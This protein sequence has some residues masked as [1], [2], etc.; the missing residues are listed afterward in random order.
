M[1][2]SWFFLRQ[3][4]TLAGVRERRFL[5]QGNG[6]L[7]GGHRSIHGLAEY[8]SMPFILLG[9]GEPR[10]VQSGVV[11]A[12]LLR[13][14]GITPLLG[15]TFRSGEDR[16]GAAPVLVLSYGFWQN[17]LGGDPAIVGRTFEMND[18]IHTVIGVLPPIPQYPD[19]NDIYMPT[20]ACPFRLRP[21]RLKT[22]RANAHASS[23]EPAPA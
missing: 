17:E 12:E 7:Q 8:H 1:A 15:R 4:A 23:G 9:R 11:S 20:S 3:P 14:V 13:P 19:E 22:G 18:R 21:Q 6:G 16:L 5:G 10:R 2:S